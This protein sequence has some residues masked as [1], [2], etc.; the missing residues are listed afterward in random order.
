MINKM[1]CLTKLTLHSDIINVISK[2]LQV[3][4]LWCF[5]RTCKEYYNLINDMIIVRYK[6]NIHKCME[7]N[8][9]NPV[10]MF[11]DIEYIEY[12]I[13]GKLAIDALMSNESSNR[14]TCFTKREDYAFILRNHDALTIERQ[15]KAIFGDDIG[16]D[17]IPSSRYEMYDGEILHI[18]NK[19]AEI[20]IYGCSAVTDLITESIEISKDDWSV[21][22]DVAFKYDPIYG[23]SLHIP[24][25]EIVMQ[26]NTDIVKSL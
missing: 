7:I 3:S 8:P 19:K 23:Y 11:E 26:M 10:T 18:Y 21:K 24:T 13:S 20:Y 17:F 4:E 5:S 22:Y 2:Y 25:P 1:H 9:R 6:E 14:L 12:V 16:T 15:A